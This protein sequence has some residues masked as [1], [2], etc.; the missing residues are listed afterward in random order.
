[1]RTLKPLAQVVEAELEAKLETPVSLG[2]ACTL[3]AWW[4]GPV[5]SNVSWG[6]VLCCRSSHHVGPA[7]C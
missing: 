4:V 7:R 6:L 5:L 1:M 3:T 2:R